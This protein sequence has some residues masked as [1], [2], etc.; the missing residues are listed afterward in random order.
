M[1]AWAR[2]WVTRPDQSFV[3]WCVALLA[4]EGY[5]DGLTLAQLSDVLYQLRRQYYTPPQVPQYTISWPANAVS[6]QV[7]VE[8]W[9]KWVDDDLLPGTTTAQIAT[10][11]RA[12]AARLTAVNAYK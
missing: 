6:E 2:W 12:F 5:Y 11:L 9:K 1:L 8:T 3:N 4:L 7:F 10:F